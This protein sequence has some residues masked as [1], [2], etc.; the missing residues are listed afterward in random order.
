MANV[1]YDL[2]WRGSINEL[3]DQLETERLLDVSSDGKSW[4]DIA[5]VYIR[6]IQIYRQLEEAY[7]Q[8]VHPQKRV[9]LRFTLEACIGRLLEIKYWLVKLNHL[10]EAVSLDDIL[11]DL[12]LS[13]DVLEIPVPQFYTIDRREDLERRNNFLHALMEKYN[14]TP[15]ASGPPPPLRLPPLAIDEAVLMIQSQER[16]RQLR[17]KVKEIRL[18]KRLQEEEL[19]HQRQGG[20]LLSPDDAA[21]KIQS[22]VRGFLD[23]RRMKRIAHNELLFIGMRPPPRDPNED[24][25]LVEAQNKARRKDVQARNKE[26]YDNA[27]APIKKKVKESEGLDMREFVQDKINRW[28]IENRDP[29]TGDYPDIPDEADAGSKYI[30]NPLPKLVVIP[31]PEEKKKK[32]PRAEKI[33]ANRAAA[34]KAKEKARKAEAKQ[35]KGRREE[36]VKP[37]EETCPIYFRDH[38]RKAINTYCTRW[39]DKDE[40]SNFHQKHDVELVKDAIRPSIFEELRKEVDIE[41]RTLLEN[42]KE[43]VIAER[44]ARLGKQGRK[45]RRGKKGGKKK[46]KKSGNMALLMMQF[47][48]IGPAKGKGKGRKPRDPTADRSLESLYAELVGNGIIQPCPPRKFS[49]YVGGYNFL[50]STLEKAKITP[51]PSIAQIRQ[52]MIE[53][54][55]LSLGSQFLNEKAPPIKTLL[56]FGSR[57]VGKT[58]LVHAAA[59]AAG[60]NLFNLTPSNTDGLYPGKQVNLMMHM[61]FK[62]AK[63]MAPSIIYIDEVEKVFVTEKRKAREMAGTELS[64]RIRKELLKAVKNLVPGDRILIIG[65]TY[66]PMDC[67]TKNDSKNFVNFFNKHIFVPLP[68]YAS[69]RLLWPALISRHGG[70]LTHEFDLSTLCHLSQGYTQG[71]IEQV[72]G[73]VLT[74]RRLMK[75][76]TNPLTVE[77]I[78]DVLF[79]LRPVDKESDLVI[80]DWSLTLPENKKKEEV[81]KEKAKDEKGRQSRA[82]NRSKSA[83]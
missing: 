28:F 57:R 26:E 58:L 78:T 54:C 9:D 40:T 36:V 2:Q 71:D 48:G 62:V 14:K 13:P 37:P 20:E 63:V 3:I 21:T 47:L 29:K 82:T 55:V 12:K 49:E 7:D 10:H 70:S 6:Y 52:L 81:M 75:L 60:A 77:E 11:L 41:M 22:I 42:L 64:N 19:R 38:I 17:T 24:P 46:K 45:G 61:V 79:K 16:G 35:G 43:M 68:D 51:D 39:Q 30:M 74:K 72:I 5:Y 27:L 80:R 69:L 44:A 53:Y 8:V 4:T 33:A 23:R 25:L 50:G 59:H 66:R 67:T 1:T 65:C 76:P 15:P 83:K 34:K 32:D 56:L 73:T 31:E 18:V